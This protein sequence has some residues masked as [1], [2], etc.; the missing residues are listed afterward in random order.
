MG[1]MCNMITVD[2]IKLAVEQTKFAMLS[3]IEDQEEAIV[4]RCGF[5]FS[6]YINSQKI[7]I[8]K[9]I[10]IVVYKNY[11]RQLPRVY[12]YGEKTIKN[13]SHIYSDD[14]NTFC[15][16]TEFDIR[17]KLLPKY[18]FVNYLEMVAWYLVDEAYYSMH[19]EF[20]IGDRSHYQRGILET[21]M[22]FFLL[23]SPHGLKELCEKYL[24]S[25]N[26]KNNSACFCGSAIKYKNCHQ[27]DVIRVMRNKMIKQVFIE[28]MKKTGMIKLD[29]K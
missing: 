20:P 4:V 23:N 10:E 14:L 2:E 17:M 16:G 13:Y 8:D 12:E 27:N 22:E 6:Q 29:S 7:I 19:N 11:P 18:N 3:V 5:L 28:D 1:K 26:K 25:G 21:Y 9:N 15:L 24:F